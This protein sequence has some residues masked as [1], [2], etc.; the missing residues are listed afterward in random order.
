M[1]GQKAKQCGVKKQGGLVVVEG[2]AKPQRQKQTRVVPVVGTRWC[3]RPVLL[4]TR[5]ALRHDRIGDYL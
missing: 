2:G 3:D 5:E 4:A 1:R